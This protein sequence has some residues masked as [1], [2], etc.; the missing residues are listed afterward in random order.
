MKQLFLV[1]G[2]LF[3]LLTGCTWGDK[4]ASSTGKISGIVIDSSEG[5]PIPFANVMTE[6]PTSSVTTGADGK[7]SIS[8]VS[9]GEYTVVA[10]KLENTSRKV[11]VA[12]RAG[13]T[14]IADLHFG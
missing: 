10:I 6:P 12:V 13:E 1:I 14:T 5:A 2:F 7:Y 9:P 3:L 4:P 11:R 8:G